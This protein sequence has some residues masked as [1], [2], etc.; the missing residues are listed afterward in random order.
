MRQYLNSLLVDGPGV[1]DAV[2]LGGSF[3]VD[4][5]HGMLLPGAHRLRGPFIDGHGMAGQAVLLLQL[6]IQKVNS[7]R[8]KNRMTINLFCFLPPRFHCIL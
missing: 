6:G 8:A 5:E 1:G 4:V 3:D 7:W 2:D